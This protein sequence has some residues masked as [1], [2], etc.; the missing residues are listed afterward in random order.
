MPSESR[1]CTSA[2]EALA[3]VSVAA[4][5]RSSASARRPASV[6]ILVA[7]GLPPFAAM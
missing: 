6:S 4:A 3:A 1:S 7:S 5:S 2:P